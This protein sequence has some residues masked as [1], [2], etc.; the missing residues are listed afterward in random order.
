MDDLYGGRDL[1]NFSGSGADDVTG[2]AIQI[3]IN[4]GTVDNAYGTISLVE[5]NA[6]ISTNAFA[7]QGF[8]LNTGTVDDVA[9]LYGQVINTGTVNNDIYGLRLAGTVSNYVESENFDLLY[10][11][12]SRLRISSYNTGGSVPEVMF[13]RSD[14]ATLG[15]EVVT[16]V[17]QGLGQFSFY[18]VNASSNFALG[19]TFECYQGGA[20]TATRVPTNFVI[21][22]TSGTGTNSNHLMLT[23]FGHVGFNVN[24]VGPFYSSWRVIGLGDYN[25][26]NYDPATVASSFVISHNVY[27][28]TAAS[29]TYLGNGAASYFAFSNSAIGYY[30]APSGTAGNPAT[31]KMAFI[32]DDEGFVQMGGVNSAD[33]QKGGFSTGIK[34]FTSSG[35]PVSVSVTGVSILK[36][37]P[38]GNTQIS[39]LTGAIKGQWLIVQNVS[40]SVNVRLLGTGNINIPEGGSEV[41][42][43]DQEDNG[44]LLWFGGTNWHVVY[45]GDITP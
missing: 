38:S 1:V 34:D 19:A 44:V 41:V 45:G 3:D 32:A 26:I 30:V 28:D 35:T 9:I 20:A 5:N 27:Y 4:T 29:W 37:D 16:T 22:T 31:M 40:N 12:T 42:L 13:R 43:P 21:R 23:S 15:S 17:G 11:G 18:G 10:S 33:A 36:C 25:Y 39:S 24:P 7:Y 8:V 14:T 6:T 2:R